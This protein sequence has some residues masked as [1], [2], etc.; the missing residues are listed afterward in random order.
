[1]FTCDCMFWNENID[2]LNRVL[3]NS[4]KEYY[5]DKFLFCPWCGSELKGVNYDKDTE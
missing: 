4:T 3:L 2:E 5:G 1:M